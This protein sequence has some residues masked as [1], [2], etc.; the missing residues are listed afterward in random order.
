MTRM[1]LLS[2]AIGA[3]ACAD[4]I[5]HDRPDAMPATEDASPTPTGKVKTTRDPASG[6][7]TTIVDASSMAEWTR[8]DFE[9]GKEAPAMGPWDLRFQRVNI[10][11][12]GGAS[13]NAGVEIAVLANTT[14]A[15]V[16]T[17]PSGGFITDAPDANGDGAPEYAFAQGG[18]W[19]DYNPTTHLITPKPNVYVVKSR[20]GAMLKLAIETYYDDAG[21]SGW[22]T[23]KWGAL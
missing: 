20:G 22:L 4:P 23:L 17:A 10:S 2:I 15:A 9:T 14:F 5:G 12:N 3:A 1:T 6:T 18:G 21:T 19:Y 13:G 16:T 8:A 7:Y 11:A